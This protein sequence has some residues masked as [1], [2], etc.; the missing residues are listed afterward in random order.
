MPNLQIPRNSRNVEHR[1][2]QR[3]RERHGVAEVHQGMEAG[4][5]T[6]A[7][8]ATQERLRGRAILRRLQPH[9]GV[10]A[11]PGGHLWQLRFR[12]LA[13]ALTSALV[14]RRQQGAHFDIGSDVRGDQHTGHELRELSPDRRGMGEVERH[15][16]AVPPGPGRAC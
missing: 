7:P 10:G 2:R 15:V 3:E 11:P 14:P 8:K 6:L 9:P 4:H 16:A 5:T 13:Q 12:P 1:H